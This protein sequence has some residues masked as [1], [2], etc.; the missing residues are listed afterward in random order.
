MIGLLWELKPVYGEDSHLCM[1]MCAPVCTVACANEH[2]VHREKLVKKIKTLP[3]SLTSLSTV[4]TTLSLGRCL[5]SVTARQLPCWAPVHRDCVSPSAKRMGAWSGSR[6]ILSFQMLLTKN[7]H[8]TQHLVQRL[9]FKSSSNDYI[10]HDCQNTCFL[11]STNCTSEFLVLKLLK[12]IH[13]WK[14]QC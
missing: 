9:D 14:I 1:Y 8:A 2:N 3:W 7:W 13:I 11:T 12:I 5:L 10:L 6:K 4:F